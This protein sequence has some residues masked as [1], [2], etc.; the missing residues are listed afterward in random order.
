MRAMIFAALAAMTLAG[1]AANNSGK[2][3][4]PEE[5][6]A[7]AYRHDGPTELTLY[8]MI[9]NRSGSGAHTSLLINASQRVVFDPAGT[10]RLKAV[11]ESGDVLYGITPRVRDFYERA[12]ARETYHVRIQT[13]RVS[14]EVAERALRLAQARG[15]VASAQCAAST[16]ALLQQLPGF[17]SI[18]GTWYPNKLADQFAQ[19]PGVS[20]RKL[21]EDDAD[22]K[23]IAIAEFEAAQDAAQNGQ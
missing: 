4:S 8:T 19:L 6:T 17:E 23:A 22:D 7:A 21:Y 14:P 3:S 2:E 11:P 13:I 12:H 20:D 18:S 9:N 10:V 5:I 1:C 15:P 16:S